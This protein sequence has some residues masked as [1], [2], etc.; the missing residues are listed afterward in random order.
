MEADGLERE[1]TGGEEL[2]VLPTIVHRGRRS[3]FG[4]SVRWLAQQT[5]A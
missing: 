2:L 1:Q 5:K 4:N 3:L